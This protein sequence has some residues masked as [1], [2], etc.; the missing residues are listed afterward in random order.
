M[1]STPMSPDGAP[2]DDAV[3]VIPVKTK[4]YRYLL[5]GGR[6]MEV[7]SP[8]QANS[9]DRLAVLEEAHRRWGGKRDE[10]RIEGVA[11]VP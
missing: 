7:R 10:W 6:I 11:E 5:T 3:F 9:D 4:H 8:F 1:T 2:D